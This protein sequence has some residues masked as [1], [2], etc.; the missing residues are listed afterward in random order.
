MII[1]FFFFQYV[2]LLSLVS[3]AMCVLCRVYVVGILNFACLSLW[4]GCV[5][6]NTSCLSDIL[7][8]EFVAF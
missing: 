1:L 2:G 7:E 6:K 4:L 3:C 5:L 8:W